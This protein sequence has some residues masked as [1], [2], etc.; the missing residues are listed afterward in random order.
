M[1]MMDRNDES[2]GPD[3]NYLEGLASEQ[4]VLL[5]RVNRPGLDL[6]QK[7][8]SSGQAIAF[9]GAGTSAP[10]YPLWREVVDDLLDRVAERMPESQVMTFRE[11]ARAGM[12]RLLVQSLLRREPPQR[13]PGSYSADSTGPDRWTR[14]ET[15]G[16]QLWITPEAVTME[17]R[18]DQQEETQ[19][20]G[21]SEADAQSNRSGG[22]SW[23][24]RRPG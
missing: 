15:T 24:V 14:R 3:A 17:R 6:L 10:L 7:Q 8:L 16:R 21:N 9:L 12:H 22:P 13:A 4:R 11:H 5:A 2:W 1:V 20:A 19:G 23:H 18:M